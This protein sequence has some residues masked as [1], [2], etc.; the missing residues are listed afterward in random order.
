MQMSE[1]ATQGM[2]IRNVD[3]WTTGQRLCHFHTVTIQHTV[4][5]CARSN[6]CINVL[7]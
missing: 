4:I 5:W 2:E 6:V 1:E 3:Y 7:I